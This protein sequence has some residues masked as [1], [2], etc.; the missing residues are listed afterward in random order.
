MTLRLMK[1]AGI[2]LARIGEFAWSRMEPEEGCYTLDWLHE[3]IDM[4]A[5]Y[6]IDVMVCTPTATPPAWLTFDYPE[7]LVVK[8]DGR[9]AEH[10]SRRHYCTTSD[11]YRLFSAQITDVLSQEIS[12]HPNIV[13]WQLD[14]E[15]GPEMS[16]CHCENCQTHFRGWL[17]ERYGSILELNRRWMTGFWSNDYT[18]WQQVRLSNIPFNAYSARNLDSKRFWSEMVVDFAQSQTRIIRQNHPEALVTTN[19]MGPI[20][21]PSTITSFFRIW[22]WPAMIFTLTFLRWMPMLWR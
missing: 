9:R 1:E 20:Y 6:E 7:T 12:R 8:A 22:M 11:T 4:L 13:A 15:F 10:G 14:N 16:W 5:R 21:L 2:N 17:K 3:V 18:H 19:G